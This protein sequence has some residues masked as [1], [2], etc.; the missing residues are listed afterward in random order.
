MAS[1]VPKTQSLQQGG[2]FETIVSGL[3]VLVAVSFIV[4]MIVRTGTGHLGS[5]PLRV[6]VADATGL[7]V[8]SG[9]RVGG[10]KVGSVSGLF[11][12]PKTYGATVQIRMRDD[13]SLPAD[14][15]AAVSSSVMGETY[16]SIAVGHA[17][18]TVPPDGTFGQA[19]QR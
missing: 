8:G 17:A 13:L 16:L 3:V 6:R 9:V 7:T 19:P 11:L 15:V 5:Y 4:F 10:V 18:H 14:S 1:A 2:A 12:D